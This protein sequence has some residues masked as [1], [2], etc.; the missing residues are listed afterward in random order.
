MAKKRLLKIV[1]STLLILF[2]L[3]NIITA[4]HAYKF[5]HFY[6][7][8]EVTVKSNTQK[9]GWDKTKEIFFGINAV[10]KQNEAADSLAEKVILTTAS[11][12]K[13]EGWYTPVD[14]PKGTVC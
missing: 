2:V 13:L 3:V 7:A 6:D 11:Q 14:S 8:T 1:L 12:L 10:K 9:S 5:T 4:F